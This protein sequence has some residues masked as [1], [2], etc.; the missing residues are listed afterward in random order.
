MVDSNNKKDDEIPSVIRELMPD[1]SEEEL[2][3]ATDNLM[4]YIELATRIHLRDMAK[5]NTL[6]QY[7][8]MDEYKDM[9][10]PPECEDQQ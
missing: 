7:R 3:E 9:F 10:D 2:L 8:K 1:A 5:G 4:G 6:E